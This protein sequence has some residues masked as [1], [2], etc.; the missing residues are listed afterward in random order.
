MESGTLTVGA[1][2]VRCW[3]RRLR[4]CQTSSTNQRFEKSLRWLIPGKLRFDSSI[5]IP[6]TDSTHSQYIRSFVNGFGLPCKSVSAASDD[7]RRT[8]S[9]NVGASYARLPG[10]DVSLLARGARAQSRVSRGRSCGADRVWRNAR[11]RA[12]LF[13]EGYDPEPPCSIKWIQRCGSADETIA[14]SDHRWLAT[15]TERHSVSILAGSRATQRRPEASLRLHSA[16]WP[17]SSR[18]KD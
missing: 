7:R 18:C 2:P 8:G 9:F 5:A 17:I 12:G 13:F 14:T 4:C 11:V 16:T 1:I 3:T 15:L 6:G 10:W